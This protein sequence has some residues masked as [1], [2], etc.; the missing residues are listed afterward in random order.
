MMAEIVCCT[1]A[2][3]LGMASHPRPVAEIVK[4][5]GCFLTRV[6]GSWYRK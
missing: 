6:E 3:P 2:G 5:L 1:D 4:W